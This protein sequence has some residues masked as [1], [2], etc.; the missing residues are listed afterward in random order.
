MKCA[1]EGKL[2]QPGPTEYT[3]DERD[4]SQSGQERADEHSAEKIVNR[5]V[6]VCMATVDVE[7]YIV[8]CYLCPYITFPP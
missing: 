7:F 1:L 8:T 2:L 3:R 5:E 4:L 6:T